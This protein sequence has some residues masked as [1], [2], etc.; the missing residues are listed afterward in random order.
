MTRALVGDASLI[1]LRHDSD[2]V[3]PPNPAEKQALKE[4]EVEANA[5]GATTSV[6]K[7]P[8]PEPDSWSVLR[9][10]ERK[11]SKKEN[12]PNVIKDSHISVIAG[13]KPS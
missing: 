9:F 3:P 8:P 11:E 4:A 13:N 12:T 7:I 5:G 6:S 10:W 2:P 1:N